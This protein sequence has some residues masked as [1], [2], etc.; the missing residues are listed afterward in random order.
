MSKSR[1]LPQP[2]LEE[3]SKP[4]K[5]KGGARPNAGRKKKAPTVVMRVPEHLVDKVKELIEN[6]PLL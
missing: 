5:K 1:S 2:L 4:E 3:G 6:E